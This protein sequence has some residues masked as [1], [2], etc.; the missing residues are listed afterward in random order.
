MTGG[1]TPRLGARGR[2]SQ[3]PRL[4]YVKNRKKHEISLNSV[5]QRVLWKNGVF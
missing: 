4:E 5:K 2:G 3:P 1:K